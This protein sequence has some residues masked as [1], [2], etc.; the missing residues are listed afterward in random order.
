MSRYR[1][2]SGD[3]G[4]TPVRIPFKGSFGRNGP[5]CPSLVAPEDRIVRVG[6]F[7]ASGMRGRR[8]NG[9][10]LGEVVSRDPSRAPNLTSQS[11][12]S[13]RNQNGVHL[14]RC[15]FVPRCSQMILF[16]SF[17][18]TNTV[19]CEFPKALSLISQ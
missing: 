18:V 13:K 7:A 9:K 17:T 1:R 6:P 19:V 16:S 14:P 2:K 5:G 8:G 4:D 12:R 15:S 10:G 11:K 3:E